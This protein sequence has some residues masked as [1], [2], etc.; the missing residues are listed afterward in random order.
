MFV[1]TQKHF[2]RTRT[3]A[4]NDGL[5]SVESSK[6]GEYVET[7]PIDHAAMINWSLRYDARA[8]YRKLVNFLV[9]KG[10]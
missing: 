10:L 6:W 1:G 8:L 9:D 7:L 2:L 4:E 5:V 3:G